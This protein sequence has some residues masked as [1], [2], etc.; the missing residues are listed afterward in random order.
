MPRTSTLVLQGDVTVLVQTRVTESNG[1]DVDPD[2]LSIPSDAG[3]VVTLGPVTITLP[4]VAAT[5]E[6]SC[7]AFLAS[8]GGSG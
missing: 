2:V 3:L 4:A 7:Q 8:P 1:G 5:D 6:V